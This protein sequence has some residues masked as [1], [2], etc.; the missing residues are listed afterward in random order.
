VH[1]NPT[2]KV[3]ETVS[4]RSERRQIYVVAYKQETTV[5]APLIYLD[6]LRLQ[7]L[8]HHQQTSL[9]AAAATT[10]VNHHHHDH[11]QELNSC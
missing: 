11:E 6:V 3:E 10:R 1:V 8:F 5:D 9:P 2:R 4:T 7:L